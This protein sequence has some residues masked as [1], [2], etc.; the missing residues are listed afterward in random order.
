MI[1]VVLDTNI[2]ISALIF[3][4]SAP[5]EVLIL[6]KKRQISIYVS[7]F[8]LKEIKNILIIKFDYSEDYVEKILD[9][10]LKFANLIKPITKIDIIKEKKDDN[11]ILECAVSAKADF[12][13]SGDKKHILCLKKIKSTRI[14]SAREFLNY[15]NKIKFSFD[16]TAK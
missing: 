16:P 3:P 11:H 9:E 1:K 12:L 10:I 7:P 8:I 5:E 15:F 6:G 14:V 2:Y 13:I 4:G